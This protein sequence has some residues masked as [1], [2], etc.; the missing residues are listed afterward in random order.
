LLGSVLS[1]YKNI[2]VRGHKQESMKRNPVN[3]VKVEVYDTEVNKVYKN[4]LWICASGKKRNIL[5]ANEVYNYYKSRFDIEHFFKF[6]KSKLRF[7]KFQTTDP[8]LDEDY[9]M[10]AMITYNHLYHLKDYASL[11]KEYDWHKS[12]GRNSTPS[13]VYRSI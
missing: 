10:F 4:D 3:Y 5:T 11:T 6:A 1:E 13:L 12:K 2:L 7:D 9:C 8:E